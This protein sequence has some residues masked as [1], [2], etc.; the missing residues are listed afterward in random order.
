[1]CTGHHVDREIRDDLLYFF[2]KMARCPRLTKYGVCWDRHCGEHSRPQEITCIFE[3]KHGKCQDPSDDCRLF[4]SHRDDDLLKVRK[5]REQVCEDPHCSRDEC[6]F[7]H[8]RRY[9]IEMNQRVLA[10]ESRDKEL[11][12]QKAK[13][14]QQVEDL[15]RPIKERYREN[16]SYLSDD[17]KK[18]GRGLLH[19]LE[20]EISD[21]ILAERD[22][23]IDLVKIRAEGAKETTK[24]LDELIKSRPAEVPIRDDGHVDQRRYL[25]FPSDEILEP[26]CGICFD[27]YLPDDVISVLPCQHHY[28]GLCVEGVDGCPSCL[29][30]QGLL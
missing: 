28:H 3:A 10:R 16:E 27:D 26:H 1:V 7:D 19:I 6:P 13:L 8:G 22:G 12:E 9:Q 5:L 4:F 14:D 20:R 23:R 24:L 11:M 15:I 17:K 29:M 21:T 30:E 2:I 25:I 18:R